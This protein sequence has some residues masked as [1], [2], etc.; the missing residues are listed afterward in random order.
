MFGEGDF[1]RSIGQA[2]VTTDNT[3]TTMD[4]TANS[5]SNLIRSKEGELLSNDI[6]AEEKEVREQRIDGRT[7][8]NNSELN[9]RVNISRPQIMNND[10]DHPHFNSKIE[11]SFLTNELESPHLVKSS[12]FQHGQFTPTNTSSP[13]HRRATDSKVQSTYPIALR[14]T[15]SY[16]YTTAQQNL[17]FSAKKLCVDN[18]TCRRSDTFF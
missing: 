4:S 17:Q 1:C 16:T 14:K 13:S 9:G 2:A 7:D 15:V 12:L 10:D 5:T 8:I 18:A 3:I 6:T 11:A